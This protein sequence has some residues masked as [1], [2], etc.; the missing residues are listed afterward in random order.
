MPSQL[1]LQKK[2][3]IPKY[4]EYSVITLIHNMR[5]EVFNKQTCTLSCHQHFTHQRYEQPPPPTPLATALPPLLP[6]LHAKV[7]CVISPMRTVP[8]LKLRM[9]SAS[10]ID[11]LSS[12]TRQTPHYHAP[13]SHAII[14]RHHHTPSSHAT[15]TCHQRST[16]EPVRHET[17]QVRHCAPWAPQ[18]GLVYT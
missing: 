16:T 5:H 3:Q 11:C 10:P 4:N 2:K 15:M 18:Q 7:S 12:V 8:L 17:G 14:T 13:S 1:H 9:P 6:L